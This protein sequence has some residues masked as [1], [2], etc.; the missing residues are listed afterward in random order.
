MEAVEGWRG[1]LNPVDSSCSISTC[2]KEEEIQRDYGS[3]SMPLI[4]DLCGGWFGISSLSGMHRLWLCCS[5]KCENLYWGLHQNL[6]WNK[7][8]SVGFGT[9]RCS[10]RRLTSLKIAGSSAGFMCLHAQF[11]GYLVS[12]KHL[13]F[14]SIAFS[15]NSFRWHLGC[16]KKKKNLTQVP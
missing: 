12:L 4:A 5:C 8:M 1:M 2:C 3:A 7:L 15:E 9:D 10:P 6:S 16:L 14:A 13:I 11:N